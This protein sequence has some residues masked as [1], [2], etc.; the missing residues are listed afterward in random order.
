MKDYSLLSIFCI[1]IIILTSCQEGK[2]Q[3]EQKHLAQTTSVIKKNTPKTEYGF[4]LDDYKLIHDTIKSGDSFG[5][6]MDSNGVS[7]KMVY[8]IVNRVEDSFNIKKINAGRP[9][10]IVRDKEHSDKV[11]AFIYQRDKINY[12]VINIGDSIWV[13]HKKHPVTIK[14]RSISGIINSS[15]SASMSEAG[16]NISLIHELANLYQWKIDFFHIQKGDKFK[17]IYNE[18]YIND[19]VYA[20]IAHIDAAQFINYG[21]SYYAFRY[22]KD[23]ITKFPKYYDE[24]AKSLQNFFLK[25]PVKFTRI[26]SRY[27]K[28]RFHPV[29]HRWKSHL[30]TDYAAPT[31]TPIHSTADGVVIASRYTRFNGNYVKI[32]HNRKYTTQYLH[33]SKRKAK[34]G[35]HVK[36]GQVIGFVGQTGLATGPHVCYRFWVNGKQVDPYK[37]K[38]PNSDPLPDLL[39]P[40]YFKSIASL[41]ESLDQMKVRGPKEQENFAGLLQ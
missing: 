2:D 19:S 5:N 25:A 22:G 4:N 15:L 38:M 39:K 17:V 20:G 28:R 24:K 36:Q 8:K 6:I 35:Q 18:K 13:T 10:V 37:Q 26:S 12:T 3:K 16:A 21:Q 1:C 41:K 31:G 29:Q 27:T 33:M 32:R 7:P 9:Y 23:S 40:E 11:T 34:V 14:K 30:G